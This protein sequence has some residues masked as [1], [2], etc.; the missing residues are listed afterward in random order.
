M[1]RQ[2]QRAEQ[3]ISVEKVALPG[4]ATDRH[5]Q[6]CRNAREVFGFFFSLD[7]YLPNDLCGGFCPDYCCTKDMSGQLGA[8]AKVP[9]LRG[10]TPSR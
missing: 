6:R 8:Q 10:I 9:P 7:F 4:S 2:R 5:F 1:Q 3:S